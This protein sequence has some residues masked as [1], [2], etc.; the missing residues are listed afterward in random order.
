MT[1]RKSAALFLHPSHYIYASELPPGGY[2]ICYTIFMSKRIILI[3]GMPT[4]GKST[5]AEGLARHFNLPWI[6]TDQIRTVM[7]S[8][9]DRAIYPELFNASDYSAEDFLTKYTAEEIADMEFR[10]GAET[11]IGIQHFINNDWTWRNGVVIEGVD[12]LPNLVKQSFDRNQDIKAV[13][14]SDSNEYRITQVVYSRGLF[15]DAD[16][17]SDAVKMKEVEWVKIFDDMIRA[18]ALEAGYPIVDIE[19]D[20]SD[21]QKVIEKVS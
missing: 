12:I 18:D 16:K 21:L 4:V 7:K 11:W 19:K 2:F 17:Y 8:V 20:S 9:A 14:L 10:Q 5:I 1:E 15:D 13:F 3:G 6:S